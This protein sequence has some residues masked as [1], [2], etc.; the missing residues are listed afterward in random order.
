MH[1]RARPI[2]PYAVRAERRRLELAAGLERF[3]N[4]AHAFSDIQALYVYGSFARD[5]VGPRSDLDILVIRETALRGPARGEDFVERAL[6]G[7]SFDVTVL[8]PAEFAIAARASSFW[9]TA[10]AE[11]QCVYAARP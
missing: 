11:A 2:E 10:L 6:P 8:T 9:Q 4:A 5:D 7:V 3:V 1:E